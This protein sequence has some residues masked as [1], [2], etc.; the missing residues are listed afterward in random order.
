MSTLAA[1][2]PILIVCVGTAGMI[3][4]KNLLMKLLSLNIVN[5][6]TILFFVLIVYRPGERAPIGPVSSSLLADPL[7]QALVLTS[8][9]INFGVLALSLLFTMVLVKSYHTLDIE[10]IEALVREDYAGEKS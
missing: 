2:I 3:L 10:K 4:K 6:A 5:T 8:V 1:V 7:P 9:V